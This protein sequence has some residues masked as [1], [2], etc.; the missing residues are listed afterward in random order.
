MPN[1]NFENQS[2]ESPPSADNASERMLEDTRSPASPATGSNSE[3]S[4][5][6]SNKQNE[7]AVPGDNSLPKLELADSKGYYENPELA[8]KY[9]KLPKMSAQEMADNLNEERY[10]RAGGRARH[11]LNKMHS[12][13]PEKTAKFV[14]EVNKRLNQHGWKYEFEHTS[15]GYQLRPAHQRK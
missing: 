15:S 9:D 7:S 11:Q 10:L 5:S 3:N 6:D 12:E 14:E 2:K 13:D 8:E 1:E 4:N